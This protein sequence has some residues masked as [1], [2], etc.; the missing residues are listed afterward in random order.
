M[1][2]LESLW[3]AVL[4]TKMRVSSAGRLA[5]IVNPPPEAQQAAVPLPPGRVVHGPDTEFFNTL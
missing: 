4:R 2:C 5:E 1:T 3:L